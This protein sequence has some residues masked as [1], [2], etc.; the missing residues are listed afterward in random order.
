MRR[1]ALPDVSATQTL[2]CCLAQT[3]LMP[4]RMHLSGELGAGKST[5]ARSLL[6]ALGVQGT[7]RSPTY[8]LVEEYPLSQGQQAYH[9][10]LYR[11]HSACL[12]EALGLQ[13]SAAL[14]LV[15]WP[16]HAHGQLPTPDLQVTLHFNMMARDVQLFAATSAGEAWLQRLIEHSCLSSIVGKLH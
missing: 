12:D 9:A 11:I 6:R 10:D 1:L 13:E 7:I 8:T 5:L 14:W 4:A 2:G 15:E 16:E 3:C